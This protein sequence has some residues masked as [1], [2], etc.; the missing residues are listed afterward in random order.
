[1]GPDLK[2][3]SARAARST[4]QDPE[5]ETKKERE[6]IVILF[7]EYLV[8]KRFIN[9]EFSG[10]PQNDSDLNMQVAATA[11]GRW[12]VSFSPKTRWSVRRKEMIVINMSP[13]LIQ[14]SVKMHTLT[15][16]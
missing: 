16:F 7:Q 13:F 14:E 9:T 8:C 4:D 1:M 5:E 11:I 3:S 15:Y 12:V 2:Q 10:F 6:K